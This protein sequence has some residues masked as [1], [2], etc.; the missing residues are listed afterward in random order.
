[1]DLYAVIDQ[2]AALLQSNRSAPRLEGI[3]GMR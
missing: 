2:V 3:I 1:M